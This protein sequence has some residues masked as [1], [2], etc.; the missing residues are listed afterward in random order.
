[1][2]KYETQPGKIILIQQRTLQTRDLCYSSDLTLTVNNNCCSYTVPLK[3]YSGSYSGTVSLM[4][5]FCFINRQLVDYVLSVLSNFHPNI[6]FTNEL[7]H[8]RK[9]NFLDF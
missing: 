5:T 1:M 7:E 6:H 2:L 3:F 4:I 8:L 9:L